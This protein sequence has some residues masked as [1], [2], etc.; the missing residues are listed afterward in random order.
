MCRLNRALYGLKQAPRAWYKR[1]AQALLIYG[2]R[3]SKCDSSLFIYTTKGVTL[4]A[5][6]YADN[7]I[8]T[9][10]SSKLVNEIIN[11][12]KSMFALK[13]LGRPNYFLGL[14]VRHQ[15]NGSIIMTQS[16]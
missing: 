7:I 2:F 14:E 16:K 1:L 3:A 9:R 8:I 11:K 12:L 10:S 6:V 4:C 13:E 15:V 5:L